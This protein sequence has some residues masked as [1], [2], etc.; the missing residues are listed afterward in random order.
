ML[1]TRCELPQPSREKTTLDLPRD[2]SD[3]SE[4]YL[5]IIEEVEFLGPLLWGGFYSAD[6]LPRKWCFFTIF[7]P[8]LP[9]LGSRLGSVLAMVLQR[10]AFQKSH[11]LGKGLASCFGKVVFFK[12]LLLSWFWGQREGGNHEDGNKKEVQKRRWEAWVEKMIE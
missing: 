12:A 6:D 1:M 2:D 9:S 5:K 11:G 8:F 10:V 7:F 3:V 4:P